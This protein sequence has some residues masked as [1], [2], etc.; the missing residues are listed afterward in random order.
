MSTLLRMDPETLPR[1]LVFTPP[2]TEAEFE[3]LCRESD[4]IRFERTKEGTI[5]MNPPA[6]GWTSDGNAEILHQLRSWWD[7]HEQGRVFDSSAGF[8][9]GDGSVLSP[10]ASYASAEALS[11][12][13]H[14]ELKDFPRLCPDFVIELLSHSDALSKLKQKMEDWMA[15][16]AAL[17]WLVEPYGRQVII[18]RAGDVPAIVDGISVSGSGPV[19]GFVLNLSKVWARYEA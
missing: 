14:G 19:A 8:R 4:N 1:T 7:T 12:L 3:V 2:L 11:R 13:A 10:D 5:C 16:G 15:N 17:G 18:Y 9:L 6:G